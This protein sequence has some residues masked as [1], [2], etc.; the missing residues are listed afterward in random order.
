M[1]TCHVPQTL[2]EMAVNNVNELWL[3]SFTL[4][5]MSIIIVYFDPNLWAK[6]MDLAEGKYGGDK[7]S[8]PTKLHHVSKSLKVEV[9]NFVD[10]HTDVLGNFHHYVES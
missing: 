3:L 9:M 6:L 7:V 2:C 4:Y 8:V 5:S 10:T 1:P